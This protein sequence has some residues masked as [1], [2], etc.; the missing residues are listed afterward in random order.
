MTTYTKIFEETRELITNPRHYFPSYYLA[1]TV[2]SGEAC[3]KFSACHHNHPD[4]K[5]FSLVGAFT[6]VFNKH[7][8]QNTG[9]EIQLAIAKT[10]IGHNI[11]ST[12][13]NIAERIYDTYAIHHDLALSIL[14]F[15][16]R[17]ATFM[18]AIY[19]FKE[20]RS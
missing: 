20:P 17:D 4:V 10:L 11:V 14:S 3:N 13:I 16:I 2:F 6:R 1:F 18:E 19:D 8:P 5:S 15:A 9:Y 12:E 7:V